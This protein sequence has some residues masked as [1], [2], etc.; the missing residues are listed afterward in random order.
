MYAKE[1]LESMPVQN[2]PGGLSAQHISNDMLNKIRISHS[3]C[4]TICYVNVRKAGKSRNK[5]RKSGTILFLFFANL[6]GAFEMDTFINQGT[7][8]EK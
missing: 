2:K 8:L 1:P 5:M 3:E 6:V 4:T 7:Y